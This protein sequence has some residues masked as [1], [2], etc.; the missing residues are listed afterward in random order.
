MT[1]HLRRKGVLL[2]K[3]ESVEGTP[4][5]LAVGDQHHLV[6]DL[7]VTP[8][9]Q[10]FIRKPFLADLGVLPPVIGKKLSAIAGRFELKGHGNAGGTV[11]DSPE[12]EPILLSGAFIKQTLSRVTP[13]TI[14]AGPFLDGE[15][16][17]Q[18]VT[19]ASGIVFK[20]TAE[21][22]TDLVFVDIVSGTWDN[23]NVI[24]G[25]DSGAS[26]TPST[27]ET[28]YGNLYKSDSNGGTAVTAA[29]YFNYGAAT[30]TAVKIAGARTN[31]IVVAN[32]TGE[33]VFVEFSLVGKLVSVSEV[34]F[35]PAQVPDDKPPLPFL[36]A[37]VVLSGFTTDWTP[38]FSSFRFDMGNEVVPRDDSND[39]LG[40]KSTVVPDWE[41]TFQ[42]DPE[43]VET[44]VFDFYKAQTE[45]EVGAT[46]FQLGFSP[47]LGIGRRV[48]LHLP[49]VGV[50]DWDL[51]GERTGIQL[52]GIT[53]GCFRDGVLGYPERLA[54][55]VSR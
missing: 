34:A 23:T 47:D 26:C 7:A 50:T 14:T 24:T 19:G 46:G 48:E 13:G 1:V 51:S 49:H 22:S 9:I 38:T 30:N 41:P 5:T 52:V 53:G 3:S 39:T 10:K 54:M 11:T 6:F 55:L 20:E 33:P 29:A 4:E 28:D 35:T 17:E 12:W 44:S 37:G 42:I 40:V 16:I 21:P 25:A 32:A 31:I 36:G 45:N 43:L 27:T 2:V 18:A 15:L 8:D